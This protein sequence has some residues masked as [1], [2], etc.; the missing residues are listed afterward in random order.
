MGEL[1]GCEEGSLVI[2]NFRQA[3]LRF[4]RTSAMILK[5]VNMVSA[6]SFVQ[7]FG[8]VPIPT[9]SGQWYGVLPELQSTITSTVDKNIK[10]PRSFNSTF[11]V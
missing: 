5:F 8:A 7:V 6:V 2:I 1:L 9:L 4:P 10:F 3:Y 11:C